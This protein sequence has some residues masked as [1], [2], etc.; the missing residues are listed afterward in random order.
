[1]SL[2]GGSPSNENDINVYFRNEMGENDEV[3]TSAKLLFSLVFR[4][5]ISAMQLRSDK[6]LPRDPYSRFLERSMINVNNFEKGVSN[7]VHHI[8]RFDTPPPPVGL[9]ETSL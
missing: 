7:R 1:M 3:S 6:A 2:L 9:Y 4:H 8:R 5:E